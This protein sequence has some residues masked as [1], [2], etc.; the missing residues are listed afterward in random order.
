MLYDLDRDKKEIILK[1]FSKEERAEYN[2]RYYPIYLSIERYGDKIR[3]INGNRIIYANY[4]QS[5][6][7]QRDCYLYTADFLNLVIPRIEGAL[8]E[9][10]EKNTREELTEALNILKSYRRVSINSPEI[11]LNKK[12]TSYEVPTEEGEKFLLGVINTLKGILSLLKCY[13]EALKEFLEWVGY[14]ELLPKEF[15]DMEKDLFYRFQRLEPRIS[16][17][18]PDANKFPLLFARNK[19]SEELL[20]IDY[21]ALPRTIDIFKDKNPF[22]DYFRSFFKY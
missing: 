13:L 4:I 1:S 8:E 16:H 7:I 12:T 5:S 11:K 3:A 22:A 14:P 17:Q 2:K 20:S 10:K 9:S 18:N 15:A 6:L 21:K 19:V